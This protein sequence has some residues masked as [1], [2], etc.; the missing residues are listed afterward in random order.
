[1]PAPSTPRERSLVKSST[2]N[3]IAHKLPTQDVLSSTPPRLRLLMGLTLLKAVSLRFCGTHR[4]ACQCG[5]LPA[6]T[7]LLIS[8]T[9]RP[10]PQIGVRQQVL[11]VLRRAISL[12]ISTITRWSLI[13]LSVGAGLVV[14]MVLLAAPGHVLRW[15]QTR[16]TLPVSWSICVA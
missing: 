5:T 14:L 3:A 4:P 6:P 15:L 9:K 2:R 10:R 11:G 16:P 1:M 12:T 13:P 7:F 8:P